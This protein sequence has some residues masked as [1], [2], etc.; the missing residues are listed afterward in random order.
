MENRYS[1]Q[2][3]FQPIGMSGQRQLADAHAVIIGCGALGS[4]IS[5][6]LVRAGIGKV[7]LADRDY[8][9]ASNLQRQQLF[10]EADAKNS[11]P[12]VVAAKR[13]LHAIREDVEIITLLDHID[14]P[15]L[16]EIAVGADILLDATDNFETRLLINDVAWKLNIPWVYGAV[17]SSS[18][19]VFPFI[20][21]KTPCF[22][23]LLPVMPAVNETCDTVGVIAPAVQISAAHQSAEAMK[24]LT[25]NESAMRTKLLHF[26]VWNNTSVEAGISRMKKPQCETCGDHPTYPAL[27]QAAGTQYAVLCGRDTVQIIPDAG[28]QLTVANGVKVAKQL[29]STFRETPFFVEFQAEGYR[30]IL[31][32]NGR[33]LIHGLK[34]MREGR[35]IYHSLFG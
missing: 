19:S 5:E 14:G 1:R 16:E 22:R 35:K 30:C 17:V 6:T 13:R 18:G 9:E 8:V 31:F 3:L 11:V 29:G 7:T 34:D 2:T 4:S 26:D 24:W 21:S 23:C 10:V 15:L 20:P 12:K 25:G 32:G 33:L 28:R 27:H